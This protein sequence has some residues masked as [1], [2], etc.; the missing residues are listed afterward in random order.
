MA[1]AGI[2]ASIGSVASGI[3]SLVNANRNAKL[4]RPTIAEQIARNEQLSNA[5]KLRDDA[6]ERAGRLLKQRG[7]DLLRSFQAN[8]SRGTVTRGRRTLGGS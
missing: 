1:I 5:S 3:G 6:Q 7:P 8:T 2:L 4:A